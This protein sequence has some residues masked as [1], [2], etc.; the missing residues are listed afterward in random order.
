MNI[1]EKIS[2]NHKNTN[3]YTIT[4]VHI[5]NCGIQLTGVSSEIPK[6]PE[7]ESFTFWN[8]EPLKMANKI[9]DV[10]ERWVTWCTYAFERSLND[11]KVFSFKTKSIITSIFRAF[12]FNGEE[13]NHV[14]WK[15]NIFHRSMNVQ[16]FKYMVTWA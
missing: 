10:G 7:T 9:L 11:D 16:K 2:F 14:V 4:I 1:I 5:D 12:S 6:D 13:I 3:V 15:K 8:N